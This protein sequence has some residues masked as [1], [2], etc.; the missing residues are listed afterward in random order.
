MADGESIVKRFER[1]ASDRATLDTH[2]EQVRELFYPTS[3]PITSKGTPGEKAHDKVLDSTPEQAAELLAAG[4]QSRLTNPSVKWFQL[5][6]VDDALEEN[7]AVSLWLEDTADRMY[8]VFNSPLTN[9]APQQHEKYMDLVSYGTGVMYIADRPGRLPLFSARPLAECFLGESEEGFIDTV[10][11]RFE[12]TARQAA[13]RW[14]GK[15]PE[16]IAKAADDPKMQDQKFAFIHAVYPRAERDP[17][18]IDRRNLPWASVW[19]AMDGK[20]MIDEGGFHEMPYTTPRWTKRA[21]EVYGRGPG[22]KALADARMLQRIMRVTIRGNEKIIDP[23]LIVADDGVMSPVRV[24]PSG[25]NFARWDLMSGSGSP[26]RPLETG[27]RPEVGDAFMQDVRKRIEAAFY[28]PLLQFARDPQM[29]A[30]QVLQITEQVMESMNPILGRMQVEDLG[31]LI[32][33]T[34]GIM[35]RAGLFEE[36]PEEIQGQ[37]IKVEYVSPVA[38]SQRI[39]EARAVAQ[40]Y[41]VAAPLVQSN[42]ELLDN[43]DGDATFRGLADLLGVRKDYM[44]PVEVRDDMRGARQQVAEQQNQMGAMKDM[45]EIVQKGAGGV[46]DLASMGASGNA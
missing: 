33:R 45:A 8:A 42:P 12:L 1:L 6:V 46:A 31:K 15:L 11:R 21:G 4:L 30:T 2:L 22:M 36:P 14:P 39:G 35:L 10:F 37:E 16:K 3:A 34:F 40:L 28:M 26:I 29:T 20:T 13:Q 5:R 23:P 27:G 17:G 19:V 43:L 25:L 7:E 9:F 38:K 41:E 24:T 32:D 44:R 18:K